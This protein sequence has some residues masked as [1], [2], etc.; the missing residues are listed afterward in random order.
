LIEC[1]VFVSFSDLGSGSDFGSSVHLCIFYVYGLC[2]GRLLLVPVVKM[3]MTIVVA[4]VEEDVTKGMVEVK[5]VF[6]YGW[7]RFQG[8]TKF[9]SL[10]MAVGGIFRLLCFFSAD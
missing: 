8:R 9:Q 3:R 4:V 5:R 10:R 2:S 6:A 1:S 7:I